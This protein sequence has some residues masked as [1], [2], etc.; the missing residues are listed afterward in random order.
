[1]TVASSHEHQ[2]A[3]M[4]EAVSDADLPEG[5]VTARLGEGLV[6]DVQPGFACGANNRDAKGVPH[7]RPMNVNEDGRIDLTDVKYVLESE[8]VRESRWVRLGDVLFNNTN[9]PDLVGK[10][11]CYDL[12]EPR[13]FSNHMT[14]VRC[15]AELIDPHFCA[16]ALHQKWREGYFQTVCNNHVSQASVSRSVLLYTQIPLPPLAEQTR[17]VAK[18][19]ALLA[20]VNVV[21]ERLAKVP[22]I[23]KRFRQAVLTAACSGRLTEEWREDNPLGDTANE[24]LRSILSKR[25]ARLKEAGSGP[26]KEPYSPDSSL[27][28][29]APEGWIAA[30]MDQLTCL[31][32]SGS[33][34]WPGTTLARDHCLFEHR[35]LTLTSYS[36]KI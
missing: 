12:S 20:R 35:I 5:W 28:S 6:I 27:F 21:R 3:E 31:V 33:R 34:G 4:K 29:E 8:A 23:L 16:M 11:A 1:M 14:R 10:T 22:A 32:T 25:E 18:V 13:A 30:S 2:F 17:I 36:L 19:E 7:L 24:L 26:Y 15:R 9:S